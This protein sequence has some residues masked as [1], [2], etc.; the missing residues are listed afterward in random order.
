MS[1]ASIARKQDTRNK[2]PP[3]AT[4]P[5][6]SHDLFSVYFGVLRGHELGL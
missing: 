4:V 5:E 6:H 1:V 3:T 2:T